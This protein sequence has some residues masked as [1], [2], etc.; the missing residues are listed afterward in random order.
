MKGNELCHGLISDS[1]NS[2]EKLGAGGRCHC[3]ICVCSSRLLFRLVHMTLGVLSSY[4]FS[5]LGI[6]F[7]LSV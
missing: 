7:A 4:P 5:S 1:P 2:L 6:N 3:S